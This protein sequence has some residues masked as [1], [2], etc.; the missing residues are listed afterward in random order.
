MGGGYTLKNYQNIVE[1]YIETVTFEMDDTIYVAVCN[2]EGR[3]KGMSYTV[4]IAGKHLVG[5]VL[6]VRNN[7]ES[8]DSLTAKDITS[9]KK[10]F[11]LE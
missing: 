9:L 2:E 10:M 6:F 5:P 8:F 4:T 11:D 7:G 3:L 1:G